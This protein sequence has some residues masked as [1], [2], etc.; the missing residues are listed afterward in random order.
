M[1]IDNKYMNST[2]SEKGATELNIEKKL[3]IGGFANL[4]AGLPEAY[5]TQF[6]GCLLSVRVDGIALDLTD[7]TG[8]LISK[9]Q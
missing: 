5:F 1:Q 7:L 4:P 8:H 6:S 9:C 2:V 3:W